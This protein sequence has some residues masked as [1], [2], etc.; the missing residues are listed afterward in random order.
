[1]N[2]MFFCIILLWLYSIHDQNR[3]ILKEL[4]R[5]NCAIHAVNGN[6]LN[7]IEL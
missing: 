2:Y 1:M 7:G 4:K 6:K 3:E 5:N